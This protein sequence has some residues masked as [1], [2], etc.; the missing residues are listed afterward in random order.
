MM[1][2]IYIS[3][4][5]AFVFHWPTTIIRLNS[6]GICLLGHELVLQFFGI[7]ILF[8]TQIWFPSL[9]HKAKSGLTDDKWI[10]YWDR[11]YPRSRKLVR[12]FLF[13]CTVHL[14]IGRLDWYRPTFPCT[15]LI[16]WQELHFGSVILPASSKNS[17]MNN[18]NS[19][20]NMLMQYSRRTK[21]LLLSSIRK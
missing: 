1:E 11:E 13:H 16:R 6:L 19:I 17:M 18:M 3:N 4:F 7:S 12:H 15:S 8:I 5:W 21:S 14:Q 9:T 20:N 2:T 10:I